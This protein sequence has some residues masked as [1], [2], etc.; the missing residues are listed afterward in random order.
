MD[1]SFFVNCNLLFLAD[2][3]YGQD[4]VLVTFKFWR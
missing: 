2:V 1:R 4:S 3:K